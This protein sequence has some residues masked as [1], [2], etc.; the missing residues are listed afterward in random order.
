[1]STSFRKASPCYV[2]IRNRVTGELVK[3][4]SPFN[5]TREQARRAARALRLALKAHSPADRSPPTPR[6][7]PGRARVTP[8]P[9]PLRAT[10]ERVSRQCLRSAV[11]AGACTEEEAE[12]HV[13]AWAFEADMIA[14]RVC[15]TCA[16]PTLRRA[17]AERPVSPTLAISSA[18]GPVV[19]CR[20]TCDRGHLFDRAEHPDAL[21]VP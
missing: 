2:N 11:D 4:V 17:V 5:T 6:R 15:P 1:M 10:R 13:R 8:W 3:H 18:L 12:S 7:T 20:Y 16:S 14:Q 9:D 21:L 19:W